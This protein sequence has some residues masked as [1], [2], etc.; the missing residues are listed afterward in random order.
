[1]IV[2]QRGDLPTTIQQA[3]RDAGVSH[4]LVVS[5]LNV[6]F[7]AASVFMTWRFG[8]RWLRSALPRTWLPGWRPT[9]W[10]AALSLPVVGLYCSLVGWEVPTTRAAVMVSCYLMTLILD[11]GHDVWHAMV[12]AAVLILLYDPLAIFD[13]SLQ[14]S[15]VAVMAM[16]LGQHRPP[17]SPGGA[18]SLA[19]LVP[20]WPGLYGG[21]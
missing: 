17:Q 8:L 16:L 7:I 15:F 20:P 14:L 12:L 18:Q 21:Q 19:L 4:L 10:A 9:P 13:V 1:M 6:S 2:G 5:G 3:F 11:R